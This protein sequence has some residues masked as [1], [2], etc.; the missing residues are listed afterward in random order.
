VFPAH[1]LPPYFTFPMPSEPGAVIGMHFIEQLEL[2]LDDL[3]RH[4]LHGRSQMAEQPL[5][6]IVIAQIEQCPRLT[7]IVVTL[8]MIV[9][10]RVAAD[11][12][13]WRGHIRPRPAHW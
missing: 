7:E 4:T 5:L 12:Q 10:R 3:H 2:A 13:R 8:A 1:R 6:L 11:A 9:T